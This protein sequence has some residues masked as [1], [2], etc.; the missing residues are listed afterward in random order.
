MVITLKPS[1]Q[2]L[3]LTVLLSFF[4]LTIIALIAVP[5]WVK[6]CLLALTLLPIYRLA[7]LARLKGPAAIVRLQPQ[8]Q[9]QWLITT[10]KGDQRVSLL[11]E[12]I[13]TQS[14]CLLLFRQANKRFVS[15][16]LPDA[17]PHDHYRRL[18]VALRF[19]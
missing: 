3:I 19:V 17:L 8:G 14:A 18:L 10:A 12:S 4:A 6:G 5:I 1:R 15:I 9:G 16:I 13:V 7:C 11:G 2:F